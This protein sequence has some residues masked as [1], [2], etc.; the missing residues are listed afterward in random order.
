[1]ELPR[2]ILQGTNINPLP[3]TTRV[4]QK[5]VG[6]E[7]GNSAA[8]CKGIAVE[9]QVVLTLSI[10]HTKEMGKAVV[11]TGSKEECCAIAA[12]LAKGGF[13]VKFMEANGVASDTSN[14]ASCCSSWYSGQVSFS[15]AAG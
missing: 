2:K 11:K 7:L 8:A 9:A 13:I 6:Q 4:L 10:S 12:K 14:T 3:Y 15:T 5:Q 1:M